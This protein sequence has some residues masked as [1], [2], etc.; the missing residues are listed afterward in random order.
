DG[1]RVLVNVGG[2]DGAGIVA[3]DAATGNILWTATNDAAGYSAPVAATIGGVRHGFFLTRNGVVDLD[4]ANGKVRFQFPWRSRNNA[5]VNAAAPLVIGD[6][7]FVSASYGAG[8]GVFQIDGANAKKLW[9]SDDALSNHYA[10][11]VYQ[12]GYLYGYHGRQEYG[13]SLRAVE[14]KT[15]KVAWSVD[16]FKAGTITLA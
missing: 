8:A 1:D 12:D 7:L 14:L 4:P 15:G 10:T 13:P 6:L 2:L 11:S 16:D 3:F 9:S 5:S